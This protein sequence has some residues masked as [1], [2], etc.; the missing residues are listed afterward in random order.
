MNAD[1][2]LVVT[3]MTQ[4]VGASQ[5]FM[6]DVCIGAYNAINGASPR[7]ES[8]GLDFYT[9]TPGVDQAFA[10]STAAAGQARAGFLRQREVPPN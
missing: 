9:G 10:P 8:G 6:D 2:D 7:V 3:Y 4:K 1:A 5:I